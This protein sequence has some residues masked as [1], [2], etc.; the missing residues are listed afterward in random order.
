MTREED[1]VRLLGTGLD[2]DMSSL[3]SDE[4]VTGNFPERELE[5]LLDDFDNDI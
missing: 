4:E 5:N 2:S 1:I 3:S